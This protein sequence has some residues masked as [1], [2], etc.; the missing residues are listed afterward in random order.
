[1][2][3]FTAQEAAPETKYLRDYKIPDFTIETVDL[4]FDLHDNVTHVTSRMHIKR[5]GEKDAPLVLDGKDIKLI[6][7]IL[8][9]ANAEYE[10]DDETLTIHNVPDEFDLMIVND[11]DPASNTALEGLYV[12]N[13]M[14][15]TQCEAQGFRRITYFIDRPDVMSKYRVRIEANNAKYPILLSNGNEIERGDAADGRHFVV[16]DDPFPKPSYLFA[17]VGG[18]LG[19]VEDSFTTKS[20]MDVVLRIFAEEQ[21]LDKCPHAMDSLIKSMKWD[22]DVYGL[23][24]D[25]EIFNIVAVSHFNMG[26]MENKSLNIFNT[27]CVLAKAETAT[28]T[29]F[30]FVEAVV[31]HEYF[32]NWTGNRVTCRDWFQL[33]LKEGLTVFRDHE[34][35]SDMGSRAVCRIN[36]VRTLRQHQFAEDSSPM[37]HP[38]RPEEYMEINNFYT[39]TVYEKGAEVIRMMHRILGPEKYRKAMDL[40]FERHDGQ[41]VTCEDFVKA[42]EDGSGIDLSQFRLW[43]SQA[44]TPE[45]DVKSSFNNGKYTLTFS[46]KIPDTRGQTN[47]KPMHIPIELGLID[48]YGN[49][50]LPNETIL[51]DLKKSEQ[52]FTFEG[53]EHKPIPSILRGFSAPIKLNTD[54]TRDEQIFLIGHD[55]DSFNRWEAAQEIS[56]DIILKLVDDLDNGRELDLDYAFI[57]A[58]RLVLTDKS[59]DK[60]FIGEMLALPSEGVLGQKMDTINVDGIHEARKLVVAGLATALK[61]EML[62]VYHECNTGE[63]YEFT[64]EAVGRR[65]LKNMVLGYLMEIA[66]TEIYQICKNQ[67]YNANNMTDEISAFTFLVNSNSPDRDKAITNFYDKWH[68]DQLVLDKWFSAQ[69]MSSREDVLDQIEK[70]NE[71]KDFD[72]KTPNRV[73]SL[74]SVF[75]GLNQVRFHDKS[76]RGYEFLGKNIKALDPLNPQIAA[77]LAK[78][79]TRW[80]SFDENRQNMMKKT[81]NDILAQDG[82]SKNVHEIVSKSLD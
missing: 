82:L 55:S 53:L 27:K 11:I 12:S 41:A 70:L 18:R 21:D 36:D 80:K 62:A 68:H 5:Q 10:V 32:H 66:D 9:N 26:A 13:G 77:G 75:C 1:M 60:A 20:G 69:A 76:G 73:R 51:L 37:A 30:S 29:D 56:T 33:S 71:H 67:F 39:M 3:D 35:S 46:Q 15:C 81:L 59:L 4:N 57:D 16:W 61:D 52:E 17:L 22:E 78:Q 23:E 43:Y 63:S 79:L 48:R 47:K 40:Y 19:M 45:V 49:E 24:Y 2:L 64:P 8:N 72:L 6:S 25:L 34:F 38:V 50:L 58:I 7:V 28:D 14:F 74:I 42:M 44:G 65:R 54:L 31:A